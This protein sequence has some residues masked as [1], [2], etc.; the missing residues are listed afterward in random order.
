MKIGI[1]TLPFNANYGGILQAYALQSVLR[2]MG[3]DAVTINRLTRGVPFHMKM[4]SILRRLGLKLLGKSNVVVRNWPTSGEESILN[5]H[6]NRFINENIRSTHVFKSENDF[7]TL[8][9]YG[10][11]AFVVGSDQVWRPKYSPDLKNHFLGFITD[12]EKV[13][14][15]SYAASFGVD[16]WEFNDTQTADC[17]ILA[18]KFDAISV[19]EDTAV[20]LCNEKLGVDAIQVIDPT[21]LISKEEYVSLVEKDGIAKC[22]GTL[23][24]YVLDNTESKQKMIDKIGEELKLKQVSIMPEMLF[25]EGG[26]QNLKKC[27]FPPVTAWIRGFMDAE[28]VVT[29]SFHGTV[30]SIIFNKPF[31][32]IG[33]KK[34]GITRFSSLVNM[35]GLNDRLILSEVELKLDR[36]KTPIDFG[37]VNKILKQKQ[38][39]ATE[40]LEK[41]L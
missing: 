33:N 40:F 13:K 3:H 20:K 41:N 6:T 27:I 30:F 9:K 36:L 14:R 38:Q 5:Q 37:N 16:N 25:R 26:P 39:Q 23:L 4:L 34:R 8:G 31:L 35:F 11:E 15:V 7:K 32:A 19:R 24:V 12:S 28:Y 22:E 2:K 21:L 17:S 18:K 29:D 10:F 1:I